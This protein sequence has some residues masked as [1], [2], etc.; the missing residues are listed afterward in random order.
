MAGPSLPLDPKQ[1]IVTFAGAT[2]GGYADGTFIKVSRKEDAFKLYIG[3][4]GEGARM[5]NRDRSGTV[6]LTL[7]QYSQSNDLLSSQARLDELGAGGT[8]ALQIKDLNGTTLVNAPVAWI[9]KVADVELGD[10][11]LPRV[12]VFETNELI[13]FVGGNPT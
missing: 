7:G 9:R 8:G 4:D 5:R 3:G 10:S 11:V 12:W 6:E 13:I 2:L 1:Y